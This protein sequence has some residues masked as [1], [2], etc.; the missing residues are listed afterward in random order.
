MKAKKHAEACKKAECDVDA[1]L[2]R[3]RDAHEKNKA[4][5]APSSRRSRLSEEP[6]EK[7]VRE[8]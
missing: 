6:T 4:S 8:P 3:L 2:S 1:S 7:I 5:S